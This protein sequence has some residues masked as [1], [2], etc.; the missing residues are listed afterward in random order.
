[1]P[2]AGSQW[3]GGHQKPTVLGTPLHQDVGWAAAQSQFHLKARV[4]LAPSPLFQKF[5]CLK[6]GLIKKK[7]G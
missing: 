2:S 1:M 5:S 3:S 7:T 4:V 6:Q